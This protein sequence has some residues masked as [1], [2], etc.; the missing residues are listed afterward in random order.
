MSDALSLIPDLFF[1]FFFFFFCLSESE[2]D[3]ESELYETDNS[4]SAN[5]WANLNHI[6][7]CFYSKFLQ[8]QN[9]HRLS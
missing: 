9:S 4:D 7:Y 3:E 2:S 8:M 1:L 6:S 5:F